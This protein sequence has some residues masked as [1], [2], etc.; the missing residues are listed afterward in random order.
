MG[1][2]S[3]DHDQ[4]LSGPHRGSVPHHHDVLSLLDE[5]DLAALRAQAQSYGE[6]LEQAAARLIAQRLRAVS[7]SALR[8]PQRCCS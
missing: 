8:V 6:T 5:V 1:E 3:H 7:D 2:R 4:A